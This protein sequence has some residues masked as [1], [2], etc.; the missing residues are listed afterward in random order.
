MRPEKANIV[1]DLKDQLNSSPFLLVTDFTGL[2][3]D[4]FAELRTRLVAVGAECHVVKNTMLRIAATELGMPDISASLSGQTAI[5]TGD[6]D[7]CATA[8]VLKTFAAEFKK[9]AVKSGILD[10][11]PL[12]ADQVHAM[13]DLPPL[14]VLQA[15]LLGLLNSPAGKL[16]RTLNEPGASLARVLKAKVDAAG[17]TV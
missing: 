14:P 4:Q 9:P 15:Q 2:K 3:V 16:A 11:A 8:K 10:N 6:Q 13:A 7:I 12:S 5:V 1:K 17:G